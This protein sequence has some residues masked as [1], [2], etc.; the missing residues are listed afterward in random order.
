MYYPTHLSLINLVK[1]EKRERRREI[2]TLHTPPEEVLSR[3]V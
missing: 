1:H 3:S 2:E